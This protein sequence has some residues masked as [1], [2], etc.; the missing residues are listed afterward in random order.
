MGCLK[1]HSDYGSFLRVIP[2]ENPQKPQKFML[3]ESPFGMKHKGYNNVITGTDHPYG[4]QDQEEVDELGFNMI[5]FK[6]RMHDPAIGRFMQIDPLASDYVHNSTYAFAENKVIQYNELEGL[7]IAT[8]AIYQTLKA[9]YNQ[10][11]KGIIDLVGGARNEVIRKTTEGTVPPS[12][13]NT[14]ST[15]TDGGNLNSNQQQMLDGLSAIGSVIPDVDVDTRDVANAMEVGG[16]AAVVGSLASGPGAPVTATLGA[17]SST[18]G[19]ATNVTLDVMEGDFNSAGKRVVIEVL[20]GGLSSLTKNAPG[21]DDTA[22][23]VIDGTISVI[24]NVIVPIVENKI[25]SDNQKKEK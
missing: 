3:D 24:E 16:D 20:S 21:M 6:Y 22:Q 14:T 13:R 1:L 12:E 8:P 10:A 7:E 15:N 2:H 4:Y 5:E 18:V 25:E 11:K 9:G 19:T 17:I 23:S